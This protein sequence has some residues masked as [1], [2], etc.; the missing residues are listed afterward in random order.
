MKTLILYGHHL[1]ERDICKK[2]AE[3]YLQRYRP[4]PELVQVKGLE[5]GVSA[6]RPEH[7]KYPFREISTLIQVHK[8][9][10]VINMHHNSGINDPEFCN[11]FV[12]HTLG[13]FLL[14]ICT[15]YTDPR[16]ARTLN[17][18]DEGKT[19]IWT[20]KQFGEY[21]QGEIDVSYVPR[22]FEKENQVNL[23]QTETFLYGQDW[24][25]P[26]HE[27]NRSSIENTIDFLHKL[28]QYTERTYGG[29]S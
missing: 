24:N 18:T 22:D 12:S 17:D 2:I 19:R 28:Q 16:L 5:N 1:E 13:R 29:K 7:T 8:P 4:D 27:T 3:E 9:K 25:F 21:F 14:G 15:D 26:E 11:G 23:L 6:R 20:Q 10:I